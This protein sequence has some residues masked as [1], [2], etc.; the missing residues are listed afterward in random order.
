MVDYNINGVNLLVIVGSD[1]D[2]DGDRGG[3]YFPNFYHIKSDKV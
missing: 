1:S 3:S 2:G